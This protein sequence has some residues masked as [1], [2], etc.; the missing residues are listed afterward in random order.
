M[1]RKEKLL[2]HLLRRE[3]LEPQSEDTIS[4]GRKDNTPLRLSFAQERFWFLDQ[5]EHAHPVYNACK[6]IQLV[7]PL[8]VRVLADSL[9]LVVRRHE[10]LRTTYSTQ[11]GWPVQCVAHASQTELPITQLSGAT[12]TAIAAAI[13]QFAHEEWLKPFDL[14]EEAPLRPRLC[15]IHEACHVLAVTLHQIAFDSRSVA[16]FFNELWTAYRAKVQGE[17]PRLPPLS[18]QYADFAAWQ[19][20]RSSGPAFQRQL[21]Y[22][23]QQLSGK[24]PVLAL[25]VDKPRPPM[26]TFDGARLPISLQDTLRQKIGQLARENGVTLFVTLLAAFKAL[27]YRYTDQKD[28]LVGCPVLN[29]QLPEIEHLLGSFV[30][31]LV[32]RTEFSGELNFRTA[33]RRVHETCARA[34]THQDFPFE[35]LVEELRPERDAS[36]NPVFQVMFAF[37]NTPTP[38]LQHGTLRSQA[39]DIDPGMTKF[40][41]SFSLIERDHSIDGHIEYN[42]D[43]FRSDTIERMAEHFRILLEAV[44]VN[45]DE[46]LSQLPIMTRLERDQILFEW[47]ATAAD[48]AAEKCVHELFQD[49]VARTP[50]AIAIEFMDER[51]TYRELNRRSNQLAHYL[52]GLGVG[53]EK[54]VGICVDRSIEMVVGLLGILKAGGAYVPLDPTYPQ[55]RL[56]LILDDGGISV[57]V[58]QG[59]LLRTRNEPTF[60]KQNADVSLDVDWPVIAQKTENNPQSRSTSANLAYLIYTSGSTGRPKGVQIEH[61]SVTNCLL[62][63]G[64][65]LKLS[66]RDTWL[67]VTTI[68]FDIAAL[69][70]Y[71]P[72]AVGA[73]IHLASRTEVGDGGELRALLQNSGTTFMQATPTLFESL[74]DARMPDIYPIT[75]LCGGETLTRRIAEQLRHQGT[76]WNVYGPTESTIWSTMGQVAGHHDPVPIG[77]PIANTQIYVCDAHLGVLPISIPGE[78]DIGGDGLARGY[79][80]R[81]AETSAKFIPN[82][83]AEKSAS[84]LYRTGDRAKY[85][86]DGQIQFLGRSDHQIKLRG[87]RIEPGEI[88]ATLRGHPAIR[89]VL[90]ACCS[91]SSADFQ[92]HHTESRTLHSL[93]AYIV[94]RDVA[95]SFNDLHQFLRDK[96]P[97]YMIPSQ[98]ELLSDLP[99]TPNGKPDRS[100]LPAASERRSHS[101]PAFGHAGSEIEELVVQSWREVLKINEIE[102]HHNFFAL[103]GHSMLATRLATRL[104]QVFGIDIAL[105]KLF[106]Y[107]TVAG[108]AHYIE[109]VRRSQLGTGPAHIVA[110]GRSHRLPLS[111][112][113]RRLWYLHKLDTN[114]SAYNVPAAFR[115]EGNLH[116]ATLASALNKLAERHEILRSYVKE[117]HGQPYS[118]HTRKL[119]IPLHFVDLRQLPADRAEIETENLLGT[120]NTRPHD[121]STPPLLRAVLVQLAPAKHVMALNFHHMIVDGPSLPVFYRELTALYSALRNKQQASFRTQP[122][123]YADYAAWQYAWL[124]SSA[125]NTQITYWKQQLANLPPNCMLPSDFRRSSAYTHR[126]GL[127]SFKLS[128]ARIQALDRLSQQENVTLFMTLFATL[129]IVL[130]RMTGQ[131]DVVIGSTIAGRNQPETEQLIGFFINA[132]PLRCSLVGDPPFSALLQHVRNIC[133]DAY[134]HQDLPFDKIVEET[135]PQRQAGR[136]PIFDIVLN[137]ADKSERDLTLTGCKVSKL[138][139]L[140]ATD[141]KFDVVLQTRKEDERLELVAVYNTALFRQNRISLFLDQWAAVLD[142][143]ATDPQQPIS[144]LSLMTNATRAALPDPTQTL[145]KSWEGSIHDLFTEQSHR[146]PRSSAIIEES[147]TWTY[148]ELNQ[149]AN[150]LAHYLIETGIQPTDVIAIYAHRSAAFVAT[151]LGVLKAGA[152]FLVLDPAYPVARIISYLR[153][154]HPKGWLQLEGAGPLPME[155]ASWLDSLPMCGSLTIPQSKTKLTASLSGYAAIEPALSVSAD[156]P[157]YIAFTSGS[158]GRP[159]G[160]VGRH[161]PATH[162]LPWQKATF[163]FDADDRFAMLSGLAYN[164][165]HRD[166]FTALAF[167]GSLYVPDPQHVHKP[168]YLAPWLKRNG[169]TVLHLTPALGQLLLTGAET[170]LPSV[171][172]V[173]FGGDLLTTE[174]A[175]AMRSLTP[176]AIIGSFYGTTETQRAVS[177][178]EIPQNP[179]LT[180]LESSRGT[181]L[182]RGIKDVQLLVLNRSNQLASVGELGELCI[183]S[184]H[185]AAGYLNDELATRDFFV[186]NP[187]TNESEDRLYKTGELGRYLPDGNVEL[188]G[189]NDRRVNIRG[190]RIELAEVELVLKEHPFVEDAA[191]VIEEHI[192]S[193]PDNATTDKRLV[194]YVVASDPPSDIS[195][196]LYA[197]VRT[198]LPDYMVPASFKKLEYMP[199]NPNGKVDYRAFSNLRLRP[200]RSTPVGQPL[201]D[202]ERKLERIFAGVLGRRRVGLEEDFFR[203]GGHSLLAAEAASRIKKAFGCAL[204]L[205]TFLDAPTVLAL[206]KKIDARLNAALHSHDAGREGIEF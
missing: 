100:R 5:F 199:L 121:L 202:T 106:E 175:A 186:T 39:I 196:T 4:V 144:E 65:A 151:I 153:I 110:V 59:H 192:I 10:I 125:C 182:G 205:R 133:L 56:Q 184:P 2:A 148:A 21:R 155:L 102:R 160:V 194:A 154:V 177:Y 129:A 97:D 176:N 69:E 157:A 35:K 181:P 13:E 180:P 57:L 124:E 3:G 174:L 158:T 15:R 109:D 7:G 141:A 119:T 64:H 120:E 17:E 172:R 137:V 115:I 87:H 140:A 6:V 73:K 165:L 77:R 22:W 92:A 23:I 171:R 9:G 188:V 89:H 44:A 76:L 78:L 189:R 203:L 173:F 159:K 150:R 31:T 16:L 50:D 45:P 11:D 19:R 113:Q 91:R 71:L 53:P 101:D 68:S 134:T 122:V 169:I 34:F 8:D 81:P 86:S 204:E 62:S 90:V 191:V 156:H 197:F 29:R 20:E 166:V 135:R 105:R 12:E 163:R 198:R 93:V 84:R 36:R 152:T 143:V 18:I 67:A 46:P 52:V 126:A 170:F 190:F 32:L 136:N 70:L 47:N 104:R 26:Q 98:F 164:H 43:L 179:V 195:D 95:P 145:D 111:F 99:R 149:C 24:L 201:T 139:Q 51:I 63:I 161:G 25:P 66:S 130:H 94:P 200:T 38:T 206:A 127:L 74:L 178:F 49:Q 28:L 80:G 131:E 58:T 96:L 33:L 183:R 40:D 117:V 27:L 79:L 108:L 107:P 114:L 37:Q 142:Q 83:F 146:S 118:E 167:G 132:L 42:T 75:F 60:N 128:E 30:N 187:F 48:Y 88:E 85:L 41:L 168:R 14:T 1:N 138:S 55:E 82:P 112:A 61:R 116:K 193:S 103:G 123:Q 162:F 54:L 185:L 72:L 147:D